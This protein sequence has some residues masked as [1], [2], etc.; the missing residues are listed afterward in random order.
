MIKWSST[1]IL[2][3]LGYLLSPT[4]VPA[5]GNIYQDVIPHLKACIS[6]IQEQEGQLPA[7]TLT[8]LRVVCPT[9]SDFLTYEPLSEIDPPLENYASRQQLASLVTVLEAATQVNK[10]TRPQAFAG[11]KEIPQSYESEQTHKPFILALAHWSF[12]RV[13]SL[14]NKYSLFAQPRIQHTVYITLVNLVIVTF[15]A[16]LILYIVMSGRSS[17]LYVRYFKKKWQQQAAANPGARSL[18]TIAH[19]NLHAQIPALIQLIKQDLVYTG[20]M[21]NTDN[22]TNARLLQVIAQNRPDQHREITHL[23]RLY[24]RLQYGAKSAAADEINHAF[25]LTR[26]I[27]TTKYRP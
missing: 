14:L 23:I 1:F 2:V 7:T 27:L 11:T 26:R 9:L 3:F 10:A 15:L 25:E 19:L 24:D 18:K 16:A 17:Q 22:I 4:V 12:F 5:L 8:D 20:D 13:Q 21:H 6:L